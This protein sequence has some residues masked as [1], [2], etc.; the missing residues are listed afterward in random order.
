MLKQIAGTRAYNVLKKK[1]IETV[2]DVCRL[3]PSKYYDF[4]SISRLDEDH[5]NKNYAFLGRLVGYDA[6]DRSG[7]LI[8]RCMLEDMNTRE[9]LRIS[10][11]GR[12]TG[13]WKKNM[14][15]IVSVLLVGRRRC[16]R[17]IQIFI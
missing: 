2:E 12:F 5:L 6:S 4:T 16:W 14:N 11:F 7:R 17:V 10:W 13:N 1:K 15:W 3:F 9:R 8:V